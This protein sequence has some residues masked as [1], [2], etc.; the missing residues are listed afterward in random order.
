MSMYLEK[1]CIPAFFLLM[2]VAE[3]GLAQVLHWIPD[4]SPENHIAVRAG[5]EQNGVNN[6]KAIYVCRAPFAGG[7]HPG[8][9]VEGANKCNIGYGG[10]G[11]E[12]PD[13]DL[14]VSESGSPLWVKCCDGAGVTSTREGGNENGH[15]LFV[16]R[17]RY[18]GH[19]VHAGKT[20]T[21]WNPPHCNIEFGGKEI[22]L[23]DFDLLR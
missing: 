14:L 11:Y 15:P 18:P 13:Y 20:A 7:V 23:T 8:K 2:I 16:C 10:K 22:E 17:A 3:P 21:E 6:G 4:G 12:I 9:F 5:T 19:G 1:G